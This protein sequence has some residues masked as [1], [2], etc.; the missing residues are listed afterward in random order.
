MANIA[1]YLTTFGADLISL[2]RDFHAHPELAFEETRTASIVATLL[3][4]AGFTVREFVGKTGVVGVL[5]TGKPGPTV[6]A[7]ADFDALPVHEE[8]G[9]PFASGTPGKM[10]ACGHD[11]H[12]AILLTVARIL[13]SERE[14]L[15]GTV[16]LVFQPAEEIGAGAQAM[17]NDNALAGYT[18]DHVIGLHI[19]SLHDLGTVHVSAGPTMAA[20]DTVEITVQGVGGHAA[21]PPHFTDP[22]VAAAQLITAL[23]TVVSRE[24]DPLDQAVLSFGVI[25]GGS[26][27]NVI[28]EQVHLAGTLRTFNEHTR[29][30]LKT[31]IT[32]ITEQLLG[33][34]RCTAEITFTEGTDAVVNNEAAVQ[35]F[36]ALATKRL[37][38]ENVHDQTPMMG[39]DDMALWLQ[40]GPGV[41]FWLGARS[42]EST[43]Y[44]HHHPKFAI[45]E[46]ALPIG[47]ELIAASIIELLG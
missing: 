21:M 39:G 23:Q 13:G 46:A 36:R 16:I 15:A 9:L 27:S 11:A 44:A 42:G 45:D 17:L 41:Y 37:G 1:R 30:H 5:E 32:E 24:T 12:T 35:R 31:R 22:V 38:A 29:T 4:E 25:Q 18:V 2:R 26:V 20:T 8:T 34:L 3:K 47:V 10:H 43:S 19:T 6:L 14:N 33:A 28:P 40:Q 7:R